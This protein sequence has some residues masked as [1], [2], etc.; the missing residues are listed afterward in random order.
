[1]KKALTAPFPTR[2]VRHNPSL[3]QWELVGRGPH[4]PR[5]LTRIIRL[6]RVVRWLDGTSE[7]STATSENR[8][9]AR[10]ARS[11]AAGWPTAAT[12]RTE[13]P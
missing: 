8:P 3:R 6:H 7:H 5:S 10:R 12:W 13:G 9:A 4:P 11:S 1:M 2:I